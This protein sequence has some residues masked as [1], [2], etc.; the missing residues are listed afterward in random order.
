MVVQRNGFYFRAGGKAL[1]EVVKFS[2]KNDIR[3][4]DIHI[5][6]Y[7]S[8]TILSSQCCKKEIILVF[9]ARA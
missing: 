8:L 6:K 2:V 5:Y 1:H 7:A 3:S 9:T 4:I